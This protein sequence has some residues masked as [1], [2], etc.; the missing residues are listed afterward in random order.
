MTIEKILVIRLSALGNIVQSMGPYAAIRAHHRDAEI[1]LLT[2][3]PYAGWLAG[4]PYF[5][6]VWIDERP[7]WWRLDRWLAFA[8][9]LRRER[10]TRVYDLQTSSRSSRYLTL[11]AGAKPEWSGIAKGASHPDRDPSR[12]QR[13]DWDRQR[14][15]LKA[16]GI[17]TVPDGDLAWSVADIDRFGLRP[18][19]MILAPGCSPH[20][21][22]KRWPIERYA[23]L[24][25][26]ATRR[27]LG[28]CVVGTAEERVLGATI[29]AAAPGV[30]DLTGRT[31][32]ADLASIARA[33]SLA[34]GNDTGP[35]HLIPMAGCRSV[36]L[37]SGASNPALCAPRGRDV[38][39][40]RETNLGD[41]PL[42][43]V[44]EAAFGEV[45][46]A[47]ARTM[48]G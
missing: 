16:A 26:E 17:P 7:D 21:P 22:E 5:D 4:S 28:V 11:F 45:G 41:L 42:D 18:P 2:T 46:V 19:F 40:L 39:V 48:A 12:N 34:V 8:R 29:A 15:Q 37:F 30:V 14:A 47:E 20:R 38:Q 10:F 24:A 31:A 1:T 27:G 33:A 32:I 6:R 36:V 25:I 44:I 3:K 23:D 35:M 43:R 13:H 9:R